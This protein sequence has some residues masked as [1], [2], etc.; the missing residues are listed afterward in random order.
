MRLIWSEEMIASGAFTGVSTEAGDV[1]IEHQLSC[2]A[3][4]AVQLQGLAGDGDGV[5][6]W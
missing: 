4:I 3:L 2:E 5:G 1:D 6:I